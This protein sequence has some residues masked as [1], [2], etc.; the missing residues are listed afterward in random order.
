GRLDALGLLDYFNVIGATAETYRAE[1]AAVPDMS[2]ATAL[3]CPLAAAI[4]AVVKA[5]VI[6]TGRINDPAV[7]ERVLRD[8]Q[9]D[10]CVMTRALIADPDLPEKARQG[11]LDDIRPCFG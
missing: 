4:K 5:P 11:R 1:A 3:Y 7:A 10:L 8:G 9:A 2:F 6:A